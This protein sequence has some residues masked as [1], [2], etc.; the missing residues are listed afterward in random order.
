VLKGPRTLI[1]YPNGVALDLVNNELWVANFGNHAATVYRRDASGDTPPLRM[2]RSG[3]LDPDIPAL[4]N[5]YTV[6]F[7]TRRGEILVPN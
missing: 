4:G 5:P 1:K 7:D 2:I 3:P 6:S